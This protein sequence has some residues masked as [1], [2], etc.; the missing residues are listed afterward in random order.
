MRL[1]LD[2]RAKEFESFSILPHGD[3]VVRLIKAVDDP[4]N[5]VAIIVDDKAVTELEF[6]PD[7]PV[8]RY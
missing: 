5:G 7:A 6:I 1:R 2:V 8:Q 3:V 4:F